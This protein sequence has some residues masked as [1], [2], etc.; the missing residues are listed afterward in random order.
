M[1]APELESERL[2]L[3]P[4]RAGDLDDSFALWSDPRVVQFISGR[5]STPQQAWSRL[6]HYAGH[7]A[8]LRF[9]YWA[10]VEK[11]SGAFV[12]EAGLAD[13]HR[14]IDA[15]MRNV[16]E[17]GWV[18]A[19]RFAGKGY[20]T[21]AVRAVLAWSDAHLDAARTVCMIDPQNLASIRVAEKCGY[22]EFDRTTFESGPA[23]FFERLR[24]ARRDD[25]STSTP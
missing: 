22:R 8:L 9:G 1:I 4:H 16:P 7:W 2:Q 6:M 5:P 18:L 3:R 11:A 10:L 15:S 24:A 20:A 13:F 14:E 21:E 25:A 17:A 23:L 19:P 12:G